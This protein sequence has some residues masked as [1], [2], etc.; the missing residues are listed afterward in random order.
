MFM[1]TMLKSLYIQFALNY[2]SAFCY[3]GLPHSSVGKKTKNNHQLEINPVNIL[4]YFLKIFL[5]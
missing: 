5:T 2:V 1:F 4:V 3:V